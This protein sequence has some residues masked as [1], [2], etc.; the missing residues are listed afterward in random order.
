MPSAPSRISSSA[1]VGEEPK[2]VAVVERVDHLVGHGART[3]L[4]CTGNGQ[5]CALPMSPLKRSNLL[6]SIR[7]PIGTP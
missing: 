2:Q 4:Y 6:S 1:A 3:I 5:V 7:M